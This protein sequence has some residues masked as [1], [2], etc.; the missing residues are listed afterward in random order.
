MSG[1][2]NG[3]T[4]RCPTRLAQRSPTLA[5][6][7]WRHRRG[8]NQGF[9]KSERGHGATLAFDCSSGQP[10]LEI[11]FAVEVDSGRPPTIRDDRASL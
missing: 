3:R 2:A 1:G 8:R 6:A 7:G 11:V 10:V 5:G 4:S 9:L